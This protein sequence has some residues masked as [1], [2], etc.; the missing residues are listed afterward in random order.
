M[1]ICISVLAIVLLAGCG[2]LRKKEGE[3][4]HKANAE[5]LDVFVSKL[6]YKKDDNG[7]CYAVLNNHTD[8]FRSTFTFTNVD[9]EKAGLQCLTTK[10]KP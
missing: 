6:V 9:C 4:L 8:G 5:E 10:H 1:K 2:D 7:I 3:D